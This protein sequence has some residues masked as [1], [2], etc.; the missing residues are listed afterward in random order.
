MEIIE[1]GGVQDKE[2]DEYVF[3]HPKSNLYHLS[4]WR[5]VAAESYGVKDLSLVAKK[6]SRIVGLLPLLEVKGI[7]SGSYL[8]SGIFGS[9]GGILTDSQDISAILMKKAKEAFNR[10]N[11]RFLVIKDCLSQDYPDFIVKQEYV[12]FVLSLEEGIDSAWANLKD[13]TR[14]QI[15]KSERSGLTITMS[16]RFGLEVFAGVYARNMRDMGTPF[17]GVVFLSKL[18]EYFRGKVDIFLVKSGKRVISGGMTFRFKDAAYMPFASSL[19]AYNALCPNNLLYWEAI[20]YAC[21]S[22]CRNFD[23]GRSTVDSGT[24]HFKK[25]WGAAVKQLYYNYMARYLPL[26]TFNPNDRKY[27]FYINLWR[28]L[29]LSVA[30][31]FGPRVIRYLL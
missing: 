21:A 25:H 24:F 16:D 5:R 13:K 23:F 14:N 2:W 15:R 11:H 27:R 9:Y 3:N 10:D 28:L 29:P 12:T 4:G 20:K 19:K 7:F 22:G 26:Q 8:T 18:M 6:D 31:N 1:R 30:N 17:L